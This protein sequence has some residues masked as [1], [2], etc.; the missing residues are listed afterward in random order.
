MKELPQYAFLTH[1]EELSGVKVINLEHPFLIASIV[2][3]KA[4]DEEEVE[5]Y[6][7]AMVQQRYPMSKVKGYSIFLRMYSSLDSCDDYELQ[8]EVLDEMADFVLTERVQRKLGQF[9]SCDQSGK[10]ERRVQKGAE[11]AMRLRERKSRSNE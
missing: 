3:V 4:S 9:K 11:R 1:P 8:Q 6:M 5:K 7:E 2:E 10:S